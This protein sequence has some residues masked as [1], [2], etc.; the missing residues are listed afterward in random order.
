V[1]HTAVR[2]Q[3]EVRDRGLGLRA[4]GL[5]CTPALSVWGG[6]CGNHGAIYTETKKRPILYFE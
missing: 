3:A 5:G 1:L 6:I 4:C 2:L